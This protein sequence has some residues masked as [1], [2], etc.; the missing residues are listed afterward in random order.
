[1][2]L[3]RLPENRWPNRYA[4]GQHGYTH[5]PILPMTAPKPQTRW[6]LWILGAT[7]LTLLGMSLLYLRP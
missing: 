4:C 3:A 7:L 6:P 5:L 2:T 1:M